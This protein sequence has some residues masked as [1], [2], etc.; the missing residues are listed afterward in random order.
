[1]ASE[2]VEQGFVFT[3]EGGQRDEVLDNGGLELRFKQ[4]K[5]LFT[6][7]GAETGSVLIGGVFAPG[8]FSGA[9]IGAEVG[10][11]DVKERTDH[12]FGLRMN[13][14]EAS[15][16][17]AAKD[18]GEDG[19]GLVV[20]GVSYGD[21][22][23]F[24]GRHEPGEKLVAGAASGVFEVGFFA[25][26]LSGYIGALEMKVEAVFSCELGDEFFVGVGSAAAE[27]VV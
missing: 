4:G 15:E 7:A 26:S 23:D 5:K 14:A 18:V 24:F 19:F 8:L 27:L 22:I 6:D 25:F 9:Q 20:S 16:A 1:M 10:A 17:G 2:A 12:A 13:A 11:T 21:A 3:R